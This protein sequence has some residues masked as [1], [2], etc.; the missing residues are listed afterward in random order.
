[1]CRLG[2]KNFVR[3]NYESLNILNSSLYIN[4]FDPSHSL[5][6]RHSLNFTVKST[7]EFRSFS[8]IKDIQKCLTTNPIYSTAFLHPHI[9]LKRYKRLDRT[10]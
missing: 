7:N 9:T 5:H 1:M 4:V 6:G 2:A 3:Q 10:E 8:G